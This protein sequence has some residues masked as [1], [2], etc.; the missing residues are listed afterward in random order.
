MAIPE[1]FI[2]ELTDRSD[3]VD[4]VSGYV[5]LTKRSGANL[6]GLCPF[7]SEKTPSFSVSPD[8][9][10]YHCFGCGKGGGVISFIM[11]IENLSYPEAV[12]FLGDGVVLGSDA[13][14]GGPVMDS[15]G[16]VGASCDAKSQQEAFPVRDGGVQDG[17]EGQ[18]RHPGILQ[19]IKVPDIAPEVSDGAYP[20]GRHVLR[21]VV[22]EGEG[23]GAPGAGSGDEDPVGVDPKVLP[24]K[25]AVEG[26]GAVG[27]GMTDDT[28]AIQAAFDESAENKKKIIIFPAGTYVITAQLIYN[29]SNAHILGYGAVITKQNYLDD[30]IEIHENLTDKQQSELNDL[31]ENIHNSF[32]KELSYKDV[33][34]MYD[35][36]GKKHSLIKKKIISDFVYWLYDASSEDGNPILL[37]GQ[38]KSGDNLYKNFNSF[39]GIKSI[40]F[41]GQFKYFV[42]KKKEALQSNLPTSCVIRDVIPWNRNG[43][44]KGGPIFFNEL[45]HMLS[46]EFVRNGQYTVI[47]FPMKYLNEYV[48]KKKKDEDFGE[49]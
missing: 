19:D 10:I 35:S 7:H 13:E 15:H 22:G 8:K 41:D 28:A 23:D 38:M 42:G 49:D 40:T 3:I 32:D 21:R 12:A 30:F 9:Q 48:K 31:R 16:P 46:V 20:A 25:K 34:N 6:F 14:G 4:V 17:L 43:V 5:R 33:L 37:H 36:E 39:L 1:K 2:T 27:D 47:P 44:N 24:G 11:E 18:D 45:E 29:Q 26:F